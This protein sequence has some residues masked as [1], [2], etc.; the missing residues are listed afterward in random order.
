MTANTLRIMCFCICFSAAQA[1]AQAPPGGPGGAAHA[2]RLGVPS[3]RPAQH[4]SRNEQH[5]Q[6]RPQKPGTP[7]PISDKRTDA[8]AQ[9]NALQFGP[10]GRWWDDK[11]VVQN[12]GLSNRQQRRM[13]SIF[14]SNKPAIVDSYKAFLKAQAHLETVN[15]DPHPDQAQ[16]FAAID[17]VNQ[18][19]SSLQKAT[20]AM[21][22]QIRKEMSPDQIDKLEKLQ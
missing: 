9:H 16:V 21:L 12:I 17:A 11:S 3:E 15:K 22:L 6:N 1:F 5:N 18:A 14:N 10:A 2:G 20:S 7:A 19:R 4:G 13:D 8:P